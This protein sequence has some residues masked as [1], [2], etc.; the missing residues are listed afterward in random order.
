MAG[1]EGAGGST[2]GGAA[3]QVDET[4]LVRNGLSDALLSTLSSLERQ[5]DQLIQ[6]ANTQPAA[7]LRELSDS[8]I[9]L[10]NEVRRTA[11]E[12]TRTVQQLAQ[13]LELF[14]ALRAEV[15][16]TY[17]AAARSV[18]DVRE[19]ADELGGGKPDAAS[20]AA[21]TPDDAAE[22]QPRGTDGRPAPLS[23]LGRLIK[24]LF[25]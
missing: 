22:R 1:D 21:G 23:P 3:I 24:R 25:G 18:A 14:T 9:D 10:R 6:H 8:F 12:T 7:L 4:K 15:Q 20:P 11:D 13:F 16:A 19:L 2:D 17:Q 5:L